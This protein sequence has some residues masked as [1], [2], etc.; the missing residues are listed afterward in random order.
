PEDGGV[1]VGR[2]WRLDL[3]GPSVVAVRDGVVFDI[4]KAGPTMSELCNARSS[5][6][7]AARNPSC[8]SVDAA[9]VAARPARD[10][11]AWPGDG[12]G[13]TLRCDHTSVY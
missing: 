11:V 4:T 9:N 7:T 3:G 10:Q 2:I 1:L 5:S 12:E 6:G 8:H 13:V